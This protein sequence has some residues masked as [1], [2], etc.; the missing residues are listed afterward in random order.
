VPL[1]WVHALRYVALQAFSAQR[2]GFAVPNGTR[3][4]LASGDLIGMVLAVAALYARH[5]CICAEG[6]TDEY[7]GRGWFHSEG[8]ENGS[9][10]P[11]V[12]AV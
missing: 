11:I 12:K 9:K 5:C 3:D 10:R 1:L 6:A 7:L 8:H 2:P 4:Q